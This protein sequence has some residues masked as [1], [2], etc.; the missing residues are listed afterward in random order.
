MSKPGR[1][2]DK[3]KVYD[4]QDLAIQVI[5]DMKVLQTFKPSVFKACKTDFKAAQIA[6]K[7]AMEL[8]KPYVKYFFK[9]YSEIRKK[10][11]L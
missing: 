5:H 10:Q 11:N 8:E 2:P 4:W 6:Y 7:D 9:V 1:G 3:K